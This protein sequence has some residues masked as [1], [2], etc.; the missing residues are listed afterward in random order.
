LARVAELAAQTEVAILARNPAP[1]RLD[2]TVDFVLRDLSS[3]VS[4]R[5]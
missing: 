1:N 2:E 4:A 3:G 5:C